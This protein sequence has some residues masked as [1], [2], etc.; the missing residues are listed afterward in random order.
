MVVQSEMVNVIFNLAIKVS[1]FSR[2]FN[3]V[4]A[5]YYAYTMQVLCCFILKNKM[6]ALN[7][8]PGI[9]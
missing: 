8:D 3:L 7:I 1:K 6:F 2:F 5:S 4:L 9:C